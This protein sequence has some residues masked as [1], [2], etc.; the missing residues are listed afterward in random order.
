MGYKIEFD[1]DDEVIADFLSSYGRE[2]DTVEGSLVA[3]IR[4][5]E[6]KPARPVGTIAR[7]TDRY[8]RKFL[9]ERFEDG[10]GK[11]EDSDKYADYEFV[12]F[13]VLST[14]PPG[15]VALPD[16]LIPQSAFSTPIS[17]RHAPEDMREHG[18]TWPADITEAYLK[19]IDER[20]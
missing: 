14:L 13:E 3:A 12:E 17:R 8:E 10:W 1:S 9:L 11:S 4:A 6:P 7:C 15:H 18:W 2:D 16:D 20:H 5:Q 19:A